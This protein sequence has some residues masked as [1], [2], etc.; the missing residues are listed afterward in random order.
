M[1]T[2]KWFD[3]KFDFNVGE[4]QP[5]PLI[6]RLHRMPFLLKQVTI[7][8]PDTVL[9]IKPAGK[10]SVI[11]HLGHLI[12]LEPLW[13]S[14]FYEISIGN[15]LMSPADLNNLATEEAMF[16]SRILSGLLEEFAL[17][18]AK[19]I[20][21]LNSFAK[22]AFMYRSMHPRLQQPMRI[23]DMMYFVAEHDEHHLNAINHIINDNRQ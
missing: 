18:R 21:Q 5:E 7:P 22:E 14:R 16:N 20:I 13:Q 9:R 12:L 4:V 2:V 6:D 11:E 10:W 15:E 3:R 17:I 8:P 23:A 19:T 1:N